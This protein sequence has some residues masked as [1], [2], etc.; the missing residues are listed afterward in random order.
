MLLTSRLPGN[1]R[2]RWMQRPLRR[3]ELSIL[4][5]GVRAIAV[6]PEQ[7]NPLYGESALA[8]AEALLTRQQRFFGIATPGTQLAGF[9]MHQRLLEAYDKVHR[10]HTQAN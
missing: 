7:T 4:L 2:D 6:T 3:G 8:Q 5:D 1:Q 9:A 10:Q